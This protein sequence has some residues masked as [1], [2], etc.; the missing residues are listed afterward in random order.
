M[1]ASIKK[2]YLTHL[3]DH[4]KNKPI[5]FWKKYG[6]SHHITGIMNSFSEKPDREKLK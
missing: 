1:Q 4:Y 5:P 2:N 6:Y 3:I